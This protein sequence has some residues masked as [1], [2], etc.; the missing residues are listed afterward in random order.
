MSDAMLMLFETVIDAKDRFNVRRKRHFTK[1]IDNVAGDVRNSFI[2]QEQNEQRL[3]DAMSRECNSVD[4]LISIK[5]L[6][7]AVPMMFS[8]DEWSP[9]VRV[10]TILSHVNVK[11]TFFDQLRQYV[12]K[13]R[14]SFI[15][16]SEHVSRA[17]DRIRSLAKTMTW[18]A[19]WERYTQWASFVRNCQEFVKTVETLLKN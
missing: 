11:D 13:N 17:P 18:P 5:R 8:D 10:F 14:D 1:R 12:Q 7:M 3:N 15:A 2:T 16:A 6:Q 4:D 19:P 9:E